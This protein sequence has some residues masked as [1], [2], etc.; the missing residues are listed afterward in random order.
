MAGPPAAQVPAALAFFHYFGMYM[1]MTIL[2]S[3]TF[4]LTVLMALCYEFG[5]EGVDGSDE[6]PGD[7]WPTINRLV[8]TC[9]GKGK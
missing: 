7:I 6:L 5:P 4:S 3:I 8:D 2:L 1:L 9:K